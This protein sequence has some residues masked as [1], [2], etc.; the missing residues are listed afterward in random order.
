MFRRK[1]LDEM[2]TEIRNKSVIVSQRFTEIILAAW[3][4]ICLITRQNFVLPA[5][6]LIA[7]FLVRFISGLI[8]RHQVGDERWKRSLIIALCIAAG[9]IFLLLIAPMF[10]IGSGAAS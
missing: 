6:L 1:Q 7:Q 5:Y 2:E 9:L 10:L 3:I 8:F 4:I